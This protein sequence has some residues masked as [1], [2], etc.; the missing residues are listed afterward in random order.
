L[1]SQNGHESTVKALLAAGA[2]IEGKWV[3]SLFI[4]IFI[5]LIIIENSSVCSVVYVYRQLYSA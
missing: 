1:A 5:I 4:I 2:D 3:G